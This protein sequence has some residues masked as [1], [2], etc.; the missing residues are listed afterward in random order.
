MNGANEVAVE[1]FLAGTLKYSEIVPIV[2]RIVESHLANGFVS[3]EHLTIEEVTKAAQWA[4]Q[5]CRDAI[6]N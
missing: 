5:A 1:N 6:S 4:Q 2:R 3:D